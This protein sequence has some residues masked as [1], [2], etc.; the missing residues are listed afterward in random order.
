ML[1]KA[2]ALTKKVVTSLKKADAKQNNKNIILRLAVVICAVCTVFS[3][4]NMQIQ[5]FAKKQQLDA[6]NQKCATQRLI[7]KD[8]EATLAMGGNSE[9]ME[10][11]ARDKLGFVYPDERV[12]VDISGN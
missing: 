2:H 10:K 1:I 7:N 6:I 9:Y 3:L 12:F 8:L 11:I 4:F 5:L